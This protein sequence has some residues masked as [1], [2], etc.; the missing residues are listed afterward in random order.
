M[1]AFGLLPMEVRSVDVPRRRVVG[2][3]VPYNETTFL[4]RD[5]RGE[6]IRRNAFAKSVAERAD[7]IFLNIE[8]DDDRTVGR[9]TRLDDTDDGLV[10]EWRIRGDE[11]GDKTLAELDDGLWPNMSVKF[12]TLRSDPAPDGVIEVVEGYLGNVALVRIPAYLGAEVLAVRKADVAEIMAGF[13]PR[14]QID[15][16]PIPTS[17]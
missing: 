5:P 10:G 8:H 13:G 14:P 2:C 15:L 11:L 16:T 12:A 3:A 9:S 1:T 7:R 4:V 6:R 17:W